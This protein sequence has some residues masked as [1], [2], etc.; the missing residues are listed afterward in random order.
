MTCTFGVV[1]AVILGLLAIT[2][3]FQFISSFGSYCSAV[4]QIQNRHAELSSPF[5]RDEGGFNSFQ[6]ELFSEMLSGDHKK[7]ESE[8]IANYGWRA[9]TTCWRCMGAIVAG[10]AIVFWLM[11]SSVCR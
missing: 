10:L 7:Y 9:R 11:N 1:A 5:G 8:E 4:A 3:A 2:F 6:Q